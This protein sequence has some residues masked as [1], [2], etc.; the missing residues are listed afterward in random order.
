M[1]GLYLLQEINTRLLNETGHILHIPKKN[2]NP[3]NRLSFCGKQICNNLI[4]YG[5]IPNKSDSLVALATL[6]EPLM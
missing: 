2:G 3:V 4:P 1:E 5:V 6:P